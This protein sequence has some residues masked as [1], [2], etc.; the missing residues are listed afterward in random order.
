MFRT[1]AAV[2]L[3]S[4]LWSP[5]AEACSCLPPTVQSSYNNADHVFS[6]RPIRER[7]TA[8]TRIYTVRITRDGKSCLPQGRLIDVEV[9][10]SSATCGTT[11]A[12]GTHYLFFANGRPSPTTSPR[13]VVTT[14]ACAGNRSARSQ[15]TTSTGCARGT[16]PAPARVSTPPCPSS[17]A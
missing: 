5:V 13:P 17:A 4:A 10:L 1:V 15:R 12:L 2:A 7:T 16:S 11:F 14:N 8:N 9:P 6:G 3:A